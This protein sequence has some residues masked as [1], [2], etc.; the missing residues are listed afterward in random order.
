MPRFFA[1]RDHDAPAE[2]RRL[3]SGEPNA[4]MVRRIQAYTEPPFAERGSDDRQRFGRLD[5]PA[6]LRTGL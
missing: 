6:L 1:R 4:E 3:P 2:P 5:Q